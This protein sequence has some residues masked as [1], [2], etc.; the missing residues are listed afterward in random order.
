MHGPSLQRSWIRRSI[1]GTLLSLI[2]RSALKSAHSALK[3]SVVTMLAD[4][5]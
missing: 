5:V 1:D 3:L 4:A 2:Q